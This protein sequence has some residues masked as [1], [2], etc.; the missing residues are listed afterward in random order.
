MQAAG[1]KNAKKS[2]KK[3]SRWRLGELTE[4][5]QGGILAIGE[6]ATYCAGC[7]HFP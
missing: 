2:A 6:I 3:N 1:A 4:Q 5:A 7:G